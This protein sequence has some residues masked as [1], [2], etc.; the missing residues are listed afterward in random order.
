MYHIFYMNE[1]SGDFMAEVA[2]L[3]EKIGYL[4]RRDL[5][6]YAQ[7][8]TEDIVFNLIDRFYWKLKGKNQLSSEVV[9]N[10]RFLAEQRMIFLKSSFP[11]GKVSRETP[12]KMEYDS[13]VQSLRDFNELI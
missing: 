11:G 1:V 10:L 9:E 13:I 12:G 4:S 3:E 5:L 6:R 7:A 2:F 8:E